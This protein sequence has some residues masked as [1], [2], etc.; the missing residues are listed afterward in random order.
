M[1]ATTRRIDPCIVSDASHS[2]RSFGVRQ[3]KLPVAQST[4]LCG[5]QRQH[6]A[7]EPPPLPRKLVRLVAFA[8]SANCPYWVKLS[9]LRVNT[10]LLPRGL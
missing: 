3:S 6:R 10:Y 5:L 2:R 9:F 8:E 7:L 4:V 1:V